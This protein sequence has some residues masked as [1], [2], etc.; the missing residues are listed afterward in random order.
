VVQK[1]RGC[2]IAEWSSDA[3]IYDRSSPWLDGTGEL[4][5]CCEKPGR[6]AELYLR[7]GKNV[8]D[9]RRHRRGGE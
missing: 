9:D 1:K 2:V 8:A 6:M 3:S 7:D 4:G 5:D